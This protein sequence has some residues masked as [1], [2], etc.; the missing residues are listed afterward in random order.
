LFFTCHTCGYAGKKVCCESCV[1]Q[2]HAGHKY[3]LFSTEE[4]SGYCDCGTEK[5]CKCS[6]IPRVERSPL[7]PVKEQ[8]QSPSSS[9]EKSPV[10][11]S[12]Q[13][14]SKVNSSQSPKKQS[15]TSSTYGSLILK[16]LK[17][18]CKERNIKGYSHSTKEELILSKLNSFKPR[19]GNS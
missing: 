15:F 1:Y 18:L 16:E 6:T 17:N 5:T 13:S 19:I 7:I 4:Q 10:I 3:T 11:S 8:L 2:C 12:Q 14:F 9:Q